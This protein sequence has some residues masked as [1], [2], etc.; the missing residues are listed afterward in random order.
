MKL[1]LDTHIWLWYSLGDE[2]L[3]EEMMRAIASP[4]NTLYISPMS[5]WE[6]V[7]LTEKGKLNLPP[8]P[9][10]WIDFN[11]KM[12]GAQEVPINR[13]VATLS[14]QLFCPSQ[15]MVDRLIAATAVHYDL[16]L[17]TVD[18]GLM[19]TPSLQLF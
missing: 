5:L 18:P 9:Y 13:A 16:T 19:D 8:D 7:L 6:T 3:P 1:L 4:S 11:L 2:R 17:L 14:R 15:N 12:L 10:I